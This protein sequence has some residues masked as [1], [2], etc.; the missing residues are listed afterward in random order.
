MFAVEVRD[1]VMIAHSFKGELFGPAQALHGATFVID[2]AFLADSLDAN[3]VVIDIGRAHDALKEVLQPLN[4]KNLDDVP[5]FAGINTTTE[6]LTKHIHDHLAKAA[7][8]DK[9]GRPGS[10]L[11][12][13]RVTISESHVARAW[14]EAGI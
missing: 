8:E 12:A 4:Y 6:F 2:A 11:K 7:R 1:H 14:Y 10:E 13:I 3:G 5:E 9:L